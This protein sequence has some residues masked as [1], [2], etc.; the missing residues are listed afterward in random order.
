MSIPAVFAPCACFSFR[1]N[2]RATA[3]DGNLAVNE[4]LVFVIPKYNTRTISHDECI[5]HEHI[6]HAHLVPFASF[7]RELIKP[8]LPE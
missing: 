1:V 7:Q 8:H 4:I 2:H 5:N 6:G 3:N